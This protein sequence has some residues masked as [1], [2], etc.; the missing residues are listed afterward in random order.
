MIYSE[1][2]AI[3]QSFLC[4]PLVAIRVKAIFSV[5]GE[6]HLWQQVR[7]SLTRHA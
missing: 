4:V 6:L 5:K 2:Y 3:A 7:L 1:T